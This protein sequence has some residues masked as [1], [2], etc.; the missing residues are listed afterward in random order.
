MHDAAVVGLGEGLRELQAETQGFRQRERATANALRQG[1]A[2]HELL[3]DEELRLGARLQGRLPRLVDGGDAGVGQDRGRP[4]L[5]QEA[6]AGLRVAGALRADQLQGHLAAQDPVARPVHD[7]H[8]AAAEAA[9]HVEVSHRAWRHAHYWESGGM[10][11]EKGAE[12]TRSA[13]A[14]LVQLGA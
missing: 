1:L 2:R 4:R 3:R 10:L 13:C 12:T 8:A 11:A 14:L 5:P 9:E 7:P 6:L